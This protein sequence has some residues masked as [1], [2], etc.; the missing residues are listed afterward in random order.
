MEVLP[1]R[2]GKYGLSLHPEK[3][4]LVRFHRMPKDAPADPEN[5][6]FDFLGVDGD[7]IPLNFGV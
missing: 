5:G 3:S 4:R 6:V 2:M 1:K 7:L